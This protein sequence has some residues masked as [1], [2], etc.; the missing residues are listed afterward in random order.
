MS[1]VASEL[2]RL[3]RESARINR[4]LALTHLEGV[5][6]EVDDKKWKV[7]LEIETDDD[8]KPVL[9]PWV[10]IFAKS[11]GAYADSPPLPAKGDRMRLMSPSGII[12][13]ASYAVP[14]T[15]DDEL[16]RPDGQQN[17]ESVRAYGK[18]RVT[19]TESSLT[20]KTEKT[21]I[22]QSKEDVSVKA[23]KKAEIE[24]EETRLKGKTSRIHAESLDKLKLIIGEQAYQIRPEALLPTST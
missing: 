16:K 17:G 8:D 6:A 1:L 11:A 15:F 13:A 2:R 7:R 3:R 10:Q 9:S 21:T 4:K 20:Q 22:A 14:G 5:V 12:G 24:G 23:D 19:M 18:A